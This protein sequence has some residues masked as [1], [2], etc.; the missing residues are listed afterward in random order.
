MTAAALTAAE[1]L[2]MFESQKNPGSVPERQQSKPQATSRSACS[3]PWCGR[4]QLCDK[5]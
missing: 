3:L 2:Q 1:K 5:L 4:E